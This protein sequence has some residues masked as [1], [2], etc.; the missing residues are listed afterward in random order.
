MPENSPERTYKHHVPADVF[1]EAFT[2]LEWT[3]EQTKKFNAV[4]VERL[5][6][7]EVVIKYPELLVSSFNKSRSYTLLINVRVIGDIAIKDQINVLPD[8]VLYRSKLEDFF[9]HGCMLSGNIRLD[10][11][12]IYPTSFYIHNSLIGDFNIANSIINNIIIIENSIIGDFDIFDGS[13]IRDILFFGGCTTGSFGINDSLMR[14]L[15][16]EKSNCGNF[17]VQGSITGF[18]RIAKNSVMGNFLISEASTTGSFNIRDSVIG[19]FDISGSIVENFHIHNVKSTSWQVDGVFSSFIFNKA[20]IEQCTLI[21]SHIPELRIGN[22]C[23]IELYVSNNNINHIAFDKLTLGKGCTLSFSNTYVY[24]CNMTEF[25]ML[26]NLYF[27]SVKKGKRTI[28]FF[29]KLGKRPKLSEAN[30]HRQYLRKLKSYK[31]H[32]KELKR[33]VIGE[34]TF[35][36]SQSSLGKTEFTDCDLAGFNFEYNNSKITEVFISGGTVPDNVV[37]YDEQNKLNKIEKLNQQKSFFDQLKKVFE[38]QG[39]IVRG[40]NYH[41]RTSEIQMQIITHQILGKFIL[42]TQKIKDISWLR[43]FFVKPKYKKFLKR[44]WNYLT[45]TIYLC[46]EWVVY[47]LNKVS[48]KHGESWFRGLLFTLFVSLVG[49]HF[50]NIA[51]S[52]PKYSFVWEWNTDYL[53]DWAQFIIP[54]HKIDFIETKDILLTNCAA[55]WDILSRIFIG[56]GIYQLISAFRKHGKKG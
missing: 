12:H 6:G 28:D 14:H 17:Y 3:T 18:F 13:E 4:G 55:F 47:S 34:P 37:V 5:L 38:G 22:E 8:L 16:V 51:L 27:R 25:T 19:S 7:Q 48:N 33:I 1:I 26:G 53:K 31:N 41:A 44:I 29:S 46:S 56:Y 11:R 52:S 50:Y 30:E 23:S 36:I 42:A 20:I 43:T 45:E 32:L 49:F 9:I 24:A 2:T 54:T 10:G 35:R 39:D 15:A 21:N 40:T